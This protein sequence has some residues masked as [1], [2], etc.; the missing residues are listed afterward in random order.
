M[1][2][3]VCRLTLRRRHWSHYGHARHPSQHLHSNGVAGSRRAGVS[4]SLSPPLWRATS[5][6]SPSSGPD[7]RRARG[8]HPAKAGYSR[9]RAAAGYPKACFPPA[10][11]WMAGRPV[12]WA[13]PTRNVG[14]NAIEGNGRLV[15]FGLPHGAHLAGCLYH[16]WLD[17]LR[18]RC[19]SC[20]S[21]LS[22]CSASMF[23]VCPWRTLPG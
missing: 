4:A 12:G 23:F 10:C 13:L 18:C 20:V 21:V 6:L 22:V 1:G 15:A 8:S 9:G 16:G 2:M 17:C 14:C 5:R 7:G 11:S 19:P 3:W